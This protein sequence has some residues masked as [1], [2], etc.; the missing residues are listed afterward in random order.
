MKRRAG[1]TKLKWLYLS[2][3]ESLC[4]VHP[5]VFSK[6]TL[7]TLLV[8]YMS[9]LGR[10]DLQGLRLENLLEEMSCIRSF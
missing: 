9:K 2:G 10:L 1:A 6:D 5:S 8:S 4:E 7:V 3:C